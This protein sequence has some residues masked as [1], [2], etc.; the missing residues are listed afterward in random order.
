MSIDETWQAVKRY[1]DQ[2][3]ITLMVVAGASLSLGLWQLVAS[4]AS[5]EPLVIENV[6][7]QT[8]N[9][10]GVSSGASAGAGESRA[11]GQY[12]ASKNGSKYYLPS[13]AGANRIKEEN[14]IWFASVDEAKSRGYEPAANCKGL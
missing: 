11:L 10:A 2:L 8:N 3:W 6:P 7:E 9:L 1:Q 14:K 5:H 13:C 12:V 4:R